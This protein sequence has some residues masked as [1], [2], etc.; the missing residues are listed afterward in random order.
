MSRGTQ[1]GPS[2]RNRKGQNTL[3]RMAGGHAG[4]CNRSWLSR[5]T[6]RDGHETLQKQLHMQKEQR[7][8][9]N[10][11]HR[12]L[13]HAHLEPQPNHE[14]LEQLISK[15]KS[16]PLELLYSTVSRKMGPQNLF[17][18]RFSAQSDKNHLGR[19]AKNV[20]QW[21][22]PRLLLSQ[23]VWFPQMRMEAEANVRFLLCSVHK[24]LLW[25]SSPCECRRRIAFLP[26][27]AQTLQLR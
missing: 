11:L 15:I 1:L 26:S 20:Y 9:L 17:Q 6:K 19:T 5:C 22:T 3:V 8:A 18:N 24:W 4:Q 27:S 16:A 7:A 21:H 12:R 2:G 10:L 14:N 25:S 23:I 13:A